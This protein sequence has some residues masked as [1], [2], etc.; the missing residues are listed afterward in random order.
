MNFKQTPE[1]KKD[2][3]RLQ[4][5]WRSIPQDIKAAERGLAPLY[6]EQEGV[7]LGVLRKAFFSGK[8]AAILTETET[9]E[10]IKMRL[11][12]ESIGTSS[13]ARIIFIAIKTGSEIIF[14]EL[15]A[16]NEKQ[17]EDQT[18]IDKYL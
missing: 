3:K 7:D 2:L 17:R 15:Y 8:K 5:K 18:R 4:K 11:D 13:K 1:F 9:H 10:V 14:V 16:K 12:V 6:V